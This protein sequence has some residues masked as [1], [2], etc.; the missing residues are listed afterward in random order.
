[1]TRQRRSGVLSISGFAVAAAVL[2]GAAP[3][4]AALKNCDFHF[5]DGSVVRSTRARPFSSA[6][7]IPIVVEGAT[8]DVILED[9]RELRFD[10]I[11]NRDTRQGQL[12]GKLFIELKN[13]RSGYFELQTGVRRQ[14]DSGFNIFF[15]DSFTGKLTNRYGYV[16]NQGDSRIV[17]IVCD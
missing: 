16:T 6:T 13:G 1:M 15:T 5:E 8:V 4:N 10:Q 11:E 9:V 12:K 7:F 17:R 14:L 3:A 2:F